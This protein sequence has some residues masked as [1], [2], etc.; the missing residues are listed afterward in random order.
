[1][2]RSFYRTPRVQAGW[3]RQAAT[4]MAALAAQ[5]RARI[6]HRTE[7]RVAAGSVR[8]EMPGEDCFVFIF[9][10]AFPFSIAI[11][12]FDLVS[13]NRRNVTTDPHSAAQE[14]QIHAGAA[15]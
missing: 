10:D 4:Q 15:T 6:N 12:R 9:F 11:G 3:M 5:P 13:G 1:M 14:E 8:P 7:S 2:H